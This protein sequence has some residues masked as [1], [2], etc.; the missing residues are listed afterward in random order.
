MKLAR[1]WLFMFT[2]WLTGCA[3]LPDRHHLIDLN[4][5][6]D[7]IR[8]E[9]PFYQQSDDL[10]G[11]A[12]MAMVME[13]SG[14]TVDLDT[15]HTQIYTQGLGGSLQQ[16][17]LSSARRHGLLAVTIDSIDALLNELSHGHPVVLLLNLSLAQWP[18]WHYVVVT[19][20]DTNKKTALIHD[21]Q[22]ANR[23]VPFET[24]FSQW[25][26]GERWGLIV[27]RPEHLP[28]S[29]DAE[30]LLHAAVGLERVGQTEAALIAYRTATSVHT[31]H[32]LLW[33][34]RG[35]SALA[36]GQ[37]QEAI[38]AL[39]QTILLDYRNGAAYHNLALALLEQ[40]EEKAALEAVSTGLIQ[41][42][43]FHDALNALAQRLRKRPALQIPE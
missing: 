6:P 38:T 18:Q 17:M 29:A 26:R 19:G 13:W 31:H 40:G 33:L 24:L 10:C 30:S 39:R 9:V 43:G 27:T 5:Y 14:K 23:E 42:D 36:T 32:A 35:N 8:I 21:G 15:L 16:D 28:A 20:F 4:P 22:T 25:Y 41:A 2:G 34:G 7:Q 37:I 3:L 12:A 1:I 11:P